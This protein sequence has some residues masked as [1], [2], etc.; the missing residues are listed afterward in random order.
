MA[1]RTEHRF[2]GEDQ[3]GIYHS[4]YDDFYWFT[5]FSDTEFV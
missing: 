3:G 5:H 4:I 2:G 1:S